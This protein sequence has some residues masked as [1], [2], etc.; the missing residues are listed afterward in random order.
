VSV[1]TAIIIVMYRQEHNLDMLYSS[2][3]SQSEKDFKIYFV[4]NNPDDSDINRSKLLN[5]KFGLN[6]EY[7]KT[8]ENSGF[9]K[10]NNI[11][12]AKAIAAGC[13]YV[14]FLNNDTV[15]EKDCLSALIKAVESDSRTGVAAP[16]ILYWKEDKT[17]P[18][19]QEYGSKADFGTYKIEKNY[20]G[21]LLNKVKKTMPDMMKV[22][23]VSGAAMLVKANVLQKTGM[24]E[25]KY[26]AYGDEIDLAARIDRGGYQ[27]VVTK[28]AVLWHNHKWV[29]ENKE[30]FYFEYYLIQRNKY[31]YFKKHRFFKNMLAAYF[32]DILK[33]PVRLLWFRKVCD[34]KL[35]LYY[36]RGTYAGILGHSGKPNLSFMQK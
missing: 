15:L 22:D 12:A 5:E 17:D 7:I 21:V 32:I 23:L 2:L 28:K 6:I 9:A 1:K 35:G 25:E 34:M 11:G 19:I 18:V 13:Q 20:E 36:L 30:G 8:G 3:V 26:F 24:W 4:D 16:L 27:S 10:G 14:F 31:L 33:F 29:K